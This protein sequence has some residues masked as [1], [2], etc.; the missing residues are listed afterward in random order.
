MRQKKVF[1]AVVL[2]IAVAIVSIAVF[3]V[4]RHG[5][6]MNNHDHP[7]HHE[8]NEMPQHHDD[9]SDMT[10]L[11][12]QGADSSNPELSGVLKDGRRLIEVKARQFEFEPN[13]I[14]VKKGETVELDVTSQDVTHGIMIEGYDINRKLEPGK[15]EKIIFT[16]D[17]AGRFNF[18]CSVY[19]GQGHADMHGELIVTEN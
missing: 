7:G 15:T 2:V 16:P 17:R 3:A 14:V 11:S 4:V 12:A 10:E 13:Q 8:Q 1:W 18:H 19:C 5:G 6:N 9:Q